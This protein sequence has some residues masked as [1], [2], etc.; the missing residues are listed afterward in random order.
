MKL[1]LKFNLVFV[2]IFV[3]GLVSTGVISRR[4]RVKERASAPISSR[5][6]ATN[7]GAFSSPRLTWSATRESW[8]TGRITSHHSITFRPAPMAKKTA[9]S[10][11]MK[12]TQASWAR[13]SGT[14]IGTETT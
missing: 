11:S 10:I 12:P 4:M 9:D 1:L 2:A 3:L 7:G 5:P 13:A 14:A 8:V 6:E